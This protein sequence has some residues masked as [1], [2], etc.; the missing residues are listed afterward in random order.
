MNETRC[1]CGTGQERKITTHVVTK[2]CDRH[3]NREERK[4][5]KDKQGS[6]ELTKLVGERSGLGGGRG[7][8]MMRLSAPGK[9]RG[10]A[11]APLST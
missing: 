10:C 5:G 4:K 2:Q 11:E 1:P 3:K 6:E 9:K 8:Q 7:A